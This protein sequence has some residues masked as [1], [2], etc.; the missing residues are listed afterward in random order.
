MAEIGHRDEIVMR[1]RE[2]R[3][4]ARRLRRIAGTVPD[5]WLMDPLNDYAA[6]L[7]EEATEMEQRGAPRQNGMHM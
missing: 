6:Q 3:D 1:V 5:Q 4:S 7:E 2:L